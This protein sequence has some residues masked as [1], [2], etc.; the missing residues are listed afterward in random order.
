MSGI[1][2]P[3]HLQTLYEVGYALGMLA[4]DPELPKPY[5]GEESMMKA[6]GYFRG[7]YRAVS[8]TR[9]R[10]LRDMEAQKRRTQN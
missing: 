4:A 6:Y 8:M 2:V 3:E 5:L 7:L 9:T 1:E 10:I